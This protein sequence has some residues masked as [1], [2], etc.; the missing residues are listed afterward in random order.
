MEM[1]EYSF[2]RAGESK[3]VG[4]LVYLVV[5]PILSVTIGVM[6]GG[7]FYWIGMSLG[8]PEKVAG[9]S[10]SVAFVTSFIGLL[11]F[12]ISDFKRRAFAE[13][14]IFQDRLFVSN[15]GVKS[16]IRFEDISAVKF[17]RDGRALGCELAL[18]DGT[19]VRFPSDVASFF[20]VRRASDETYIE[21]LR[22]RADY[23][24]KNGSILE[25]VTEP[26][27][28]LR[29]KLT[30]ILLIVWA[31]T[32]ALTIKFYHYAPKAYRLGKFYYRSGR[33]KGFKIRDEGLIDNENPTQCIHW[34]ELNL[35]SDL[36]D[37][38][39]IGSTGGLTFAASALTS[40][41]WPLWKLIE[42]RVKQAA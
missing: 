35:K 10:F 37:G 6:L 9:L 32:L 30:G 11:L 41:A 40:N 7:L 39:L 1:P 5:V 28:A 33:S 16:E 26:N 23:S 19:C 38:I 2:R 34:R 27:A 15:N 12:A 13:V 14:V 29:Q 31:C 42:H 36:A 8:L 17:F 22:S 4:F 25:W 21:F 18:A 3:I 24:L 20:A